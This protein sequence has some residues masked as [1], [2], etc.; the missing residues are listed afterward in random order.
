MNSIETFPPVDWPLRDALPN[1]GAATV[2]NLLAWGERQPGS[3]PWL[4]GRASV[5]WDKWTCPKDWPALH[6]HARLVDATV[7]LE[8]L[9]YRI[10]S[11]SDR[12]AV[13]HLSSDGTGKGGR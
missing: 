12:E 1:I 2:E 9:R 5:Y 3:L 13:L 6:E 10:Q 11:A 8:L 7:A 4:L